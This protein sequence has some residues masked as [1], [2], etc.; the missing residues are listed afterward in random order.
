MPYRQG[1]KFALCVL[2]FE[3]VVSDAA[4]THPIYI[5]EADQKLQLDLCR[6]IIAYVWH[7]LGTI[8]AQCTEACLSIDALLK[9]ELILQ[10]TYM[11]TA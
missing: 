9:T 7:M 4:L 1:L 6:V 11:W 5:N 10:D 8:Y 3:S 2:A